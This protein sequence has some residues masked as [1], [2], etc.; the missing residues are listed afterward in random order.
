MLSSDGESQEESDTDSDI[1]VVTIP[2]S[3]QT[4]TSKV[5]E[6]PRRSPAAILLMS[7]GRLRPHPTLSLTVH[8]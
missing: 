5:P 3:P 4:F 1:D 6:F 2:I 7:E 8:S